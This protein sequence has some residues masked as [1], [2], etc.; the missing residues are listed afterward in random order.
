MA[1][2]NKIEELLLQHQL[3]NTEI[4]RE[5]LQV[6]IQEA[7]ALS[8]GQIEQKLAGRFDRV[9]LY[10]TLRAFEEKGLIHRVASEQEGIEYA[11]CRGACQGEHEHPVT[12][13]HH[14]QH[15]HFRCGRCERTLCLE[16]AGL[17]PIQLPSGYTLSDL[18]ILALG[19]CADCNQN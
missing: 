18:Q 16:E 11:L 14:D 13:K 15:L 5:V 9:T 3:R 2:S 4:R 10:R 17:P 12:H 6:F 8:H 1:K 7:Q 19:T